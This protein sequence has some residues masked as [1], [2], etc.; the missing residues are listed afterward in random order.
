MLSF[1]GNPLTQRH[2]ILSTKDLTLSYG[3]NWKS[4]S[5]PGLNQYQ[6]VTDDRTGRQNYNS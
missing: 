4:P 2:E 5:N 1:K 6:I 3:K